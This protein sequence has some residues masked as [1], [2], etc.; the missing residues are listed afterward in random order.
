MQKDF[1]TATFGFET[2]PDLDLQEVYAIGTYTEGEDPVFYGDNMHDGSSAQV[3]FTL[4]D[5]ETDEVIRTD[6]WDKKRIHELEV[7]I[8]E[9]IIYY[10]HEEFEYE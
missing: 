4:Y 2:N 6:N 5:A 10:E 8:I 9:N 3:E 7:A 1:T